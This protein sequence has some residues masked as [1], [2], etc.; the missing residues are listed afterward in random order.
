MTTCT[1]FIPAAPQRKSARHAKNQSVIP[2]SKRATARLS[3]QLDFADVTGDEA[4][5]RYTELYKKPLNKNV[6]AALRRA[7]KLDNDSVMAAS[8]AM[9]GSEEAARL[10][11]A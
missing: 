3:R 9:V 11:A 7:T 4:V 5:K 1:I 8:A 2:V 10:N 6:L